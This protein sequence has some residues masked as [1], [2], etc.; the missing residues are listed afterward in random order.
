MIL[1]IPCCT[2]GSCS[3]PRIVQQRR[4]FSPPPAVMQ[5]SHLMADF[6]IL[7]QLGGVFAYTARYRKAPASSI[8]A[9]CELHLCACSDKNTHIDRIH[10]IVDP[11][12]LLWRASVASPQFCAK[13][14]SPQFQDV[15]PQNRMMFSQ[16]QMIH[17]PIEMSHILPIQKLYGWLQERCPW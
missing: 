6:Q 11:A 2:Y 14:N 9:R 12:M 10:Y 13:K 1:A 7:C 3:L 4:Q 15:H 8:F 16:N 5:I 17:I